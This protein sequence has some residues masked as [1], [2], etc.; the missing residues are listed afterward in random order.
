MASKNTIGSKIVIE[1]EKEYNESLR[2]IRAEQQ[3]LRS[4]MNLCTE[5]YKENANTVEALK[6][7]QEILAKQVDAQSRKVDN[8]RRVLE[9]ANKAQEE[10]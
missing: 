10:A 6:Q 7:K 5:T 8:Q 4:E 9:S 1:G 3:E 2:R